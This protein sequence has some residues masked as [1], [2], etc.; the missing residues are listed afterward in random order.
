MQG[1]KQ[2]DCLFEYIVVKQEVE[3]GAVHLVTTYFLL[4]SHK[5]LN[6]S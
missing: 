5:I 3:Y 1:N 2:L 6:K 4:N